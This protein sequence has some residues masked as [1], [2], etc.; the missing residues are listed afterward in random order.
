MA[1]FFALT[2]KVYLRFAKTKDHMTQPFEDIFHILF[3]TV[4]SL[5]S[6]INAG[7]NWDPGKMLREWAGEKGRENGL[8]YAESYKVMFHEDEQPENKTQT[9][10]IKSISLNLQVEE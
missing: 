4:R 10:M 5:K 2:L 1:T 8:K 7:G 3:P 6:S 9:I